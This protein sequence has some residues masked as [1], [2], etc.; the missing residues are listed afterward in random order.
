MDKLEKLLK[1]YNHPTHITKDSKDFLYYVNSMDQKNIG[2]I[3]DKNTQKFILQYIPNFKD[4]N[5]KYKIFDS[6]IIASE[7]QINDLRNFVLFEN[8]KTL[9]NIS[10]GT[11]H[12]LCKYISYTESIVHIACPTAPSMNGYL[13]GTSSI[14]SENKWHSLKSK[15]PD[16]LYLN[17]DVISNAPQRMIRAG[18]G[19][20]ICRIS[21]QNDMVLSHYV[22]GTDYKKEFFDDI[23]YYENIIYSEIQKNGMQYL[24]SSKVVEYLTYWLLVGGIIMYFTKSSN[25]ASQGEHTFIHYFDQTYKSIA[26]QYLHGE[27]IM[28]ATGLMFEIQK[29]KLSLDVSNLFIHEGSYNQLFANDISSISCS[30]AL[31]NLRNHWNDIQYLCRRN[32]ENFNSYMEYIAVLANMNLFQYIMENYTDILCQSQFYRN[33]FSFLHLEIGTP[34]ISDF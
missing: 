4:I 14:Y 9:I 29:A 1:E 10:S 20:S 2:I 8:I 7:E 5:Y 12:D 6:N 17:F 31:V 34:L 30:N 23:Q 11:I 22:L 32:F 26:S 33:R 3:C 24:Y 16:Y 21:C 15:A 28:I 18:Y 13:S 19:D 25:I 27:K